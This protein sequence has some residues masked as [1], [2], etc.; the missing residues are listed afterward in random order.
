[1][2]RIVHVNY[3]LEQDE[4]GA[5]CASASTRPGSTAYGE[6]DTPEEALA[7][8]R[9]GLILLFKVDGPPNEMTLRLDVA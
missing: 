2:D 5:W 8:L 4:D 9:E 1:M 6:G 7:D 3:V